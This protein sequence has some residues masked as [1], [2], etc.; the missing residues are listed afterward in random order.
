MRAREPDGTEPVP[1]V[2]HVTRVG[3]QGRGAGFY[4]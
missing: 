2:A 3:N 1:K 4:K